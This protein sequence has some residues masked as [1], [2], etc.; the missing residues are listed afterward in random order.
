MATQTAESSVRS[1]GGLH[2]PEVPNRR[3]YR[4]P[5]TED[6]SWVEKGPFNL[7]DS[8][9]KMTA[10]FWSKLEGGLEG[11]KEI[12]NV[13]KASWCFQ[14]GVGFF[15][16]IPRKNL[17]TFEEFECDARSCC[18]VQLS[19]TVERAWF[20]SRPSPWNHSALVTETSTPTFIASLNSQEHILEPKSRISHF[21]E[22]LD[23]RQLTL[24]RK[25]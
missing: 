21:Q 11:K 15:S 22:I 24:W 17:K 18:L 20:G 3:K 7:L 23:E 8:R 12:K 16:G 13:T 5:P 14:Y 2:R 9:D 4:H 25:T 19:E 10:T 6:A 1:V